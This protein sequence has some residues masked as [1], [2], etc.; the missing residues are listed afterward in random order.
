MQQK[1]LFLI[2]LILLTSVSDY[3]DSFE[4]IW[5]TFAD[6]RSFAISVSANI[7]L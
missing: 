6:K 2:A 4:K 7:N 5:V 1:L 3:S